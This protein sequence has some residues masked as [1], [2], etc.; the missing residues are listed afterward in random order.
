[1]KFSFFQSGIKSNFLKLV[2]NRRSIPF[3]VLHVLIE[4]EDVVENKISMPFTVFHVLIENEDV[5]SV[6]S[7]KLI[8]IFIKKHCLLFVKI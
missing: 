6:T 8:P 2:Q 7:H 5:V 3:M 4:N 1:M